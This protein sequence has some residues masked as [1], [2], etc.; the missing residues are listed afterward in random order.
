[1]AGAPSAALLLEA[2]ERASVQPAAY[3]PLTVLSLLTGRDRS[4][5]AQLTV[6]ERDSLILRIR[7]ALFGQRIVALSSCPSCGADA[8]LTFNF[9]DICVPVQITREVSVQVGDEMVTARPLTAGDL[10]EAAGARD[11]AAELRRRSIG[12]DFQGS[13]D[14]LF[15]LGRALAEADPLAQIELELSCP[16]C[17]VSSSR[18][19]DPWAFFWE[20]LRSWAMRTL[21]QVHRLARAYGWTE[22][23]VLALSPQRRNTYLRMVGA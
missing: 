15:E 3:R 14:H 16:S 22:G 23:D 18:R 8:E 7:A 21:G 4:E 20:E 12:G 13:S 5:L 2:W 6:G 1:M 9:S 19:F 10:E 11:V 17:Q